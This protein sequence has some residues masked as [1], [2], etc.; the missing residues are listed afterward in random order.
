MDDSGTTTTTNSLNAFFYIAA[1]NAMRSHYPENQRAAEKL[2]FSF[3]TQFLQIP[4]SRHSS[5]FL[6]LLSSTF[7]SSSSALCLSSCQ[8]CVVL[9]AVVSHQS[10]SDAVH[11]FIHAIH[12][13]LFVHSLLSASLPG[14]GLGAA[15]IISRTSSRSIVIWQPQIQ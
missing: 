12:M 8:L 2:A 13:N 11:P 3:S 7:V 10:R 6:V 4:P 15:K 5:S 14:G 1:A 9:F